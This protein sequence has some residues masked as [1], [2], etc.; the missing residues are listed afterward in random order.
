MG[1]GLFNRLR[2]RGESRQLVK[3]ET[4]FVD[5]NPTIFGPGVQGV[6]LP[7]SIHI[8]GG[9]LGDYINWTAALKYIEATFNHVDVKIFTSELFIDVAKY[10]FPKWEVYHRR[11]APLKQTPGSMVLRTKAS[12][13]LLNAC[14]MH[15][16]DL[17][18]AYYLC[19]NPPPAKF[20]VLPRIDFEGPWNWPELDPKSSY[21]VF[22]P[23]ST[24]DVREM[25][26]EAFNELCRY[27]LG[28]GVTPVFLGKRNLSGQY[29]AK[30]LN[31]DFSLGLDLRERTN[32]LEAV[33]IMR[34]AKFVI[35]IDN[36]LLH[37]AGTTDV[38]VIFGHNIAPL[39]HRKLR[40][41][42]GLTI[43]ITVPE[44]DLACIGCQGKMRFTL[45]H[46]FRKCFHHT[47]EALN[48][49]CLSHL[50]KNNCAKWKNAIDRALKE[51]RS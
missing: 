7:V 46:D 20:N 40:R 8:E 45:N 11:E 12:H 38:P 47:N 29:D 13:Q 27:T 6:K 21:A 2:G 19:M 41:F 1:S 35:G 51:K 34:G 30:F 14:G 33:Q 44:S 17:G 9:G 22:T 48:K 37:M 16:L 50:F 32:V 25:P 18:F 43:D 28:K 36:G 15:L 26:V 5:L 4:A 39:H 49:A 24:T 10:L 23:G 42:G 3:L 31:Y